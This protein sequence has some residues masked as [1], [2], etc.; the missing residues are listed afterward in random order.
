M[1]HLSYKAI[2]LLAFAALFACVLSGCITSRAVT[3]AHWHDEETLYVAYLETTTES[4][5][6]VKLC[7]VQPDNSLKCEDQAALNKELNKKE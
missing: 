1:H 6:K 3:A 7:K 5:A 4:E 2:A